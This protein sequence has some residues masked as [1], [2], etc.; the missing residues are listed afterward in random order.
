MIITHQHF[1]LQEKCILERIVFT[2]P[3]KKSNVMQDEA[4]FL[5]TVNG[6]SSLYGLD[7]KV[8]LSSNDGVVLK[9]GSY[10]Q[11]HYQT[12]NNKPYEKIAVHFH[13]EILKIIF[14][15]F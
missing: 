1:E 3:L 11:D 14:L 5:Y 12:I 4:C 6:Q 2:S 15:N 9:C 13:K 10:L 8:E 7:Q